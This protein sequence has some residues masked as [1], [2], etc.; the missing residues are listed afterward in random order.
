MFYNTDRYTYL[1]IVLTEHLDYNV[2]AKFVSQATGRALGLLIA[3][4]RSIG[5][6]PYHVYSKL[7]DSLVWPVIAYGASIWGTRK[8][9]CIDACVKRQIIFI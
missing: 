4:F 6:M 2:T 5:G 3:K 8:F 7:Y 9:A 1:G